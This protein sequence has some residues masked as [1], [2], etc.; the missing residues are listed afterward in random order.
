MSNVKWIKIT[1][2]MFEDEKIDFIESLPESDSIIIIWIK[3]LTIAGKCNSGGFIYLTEKIPYTENML[4]HKFK[5]PLATVRLALNTLAELDMI[6]FDEES[7]LK[8]TNWE[9]HQN[10]DGLAKIREQ[11]RKRVANYR[12][13]QKQLP[14]GN[15]TSN[16]TVTDCNPRDRELE[17][18][19]EL[20][21]ETDIYKWIIEYLNSKAN[22]NFKYTSKSTQRLIDTRIKE[23]FVLDDFKK[24]IDT[25][26]DAWQV[27][28]KMNSYLRPQTLFG[29]KFEGYLNEDIKEDTKDENYY[30]W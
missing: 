16:V 6:E 20:D 17:L 25:K 26:A 30:G 21:K 22:K 19:L 3:L 12:E 24:V 28:P 4:S 1:T 5:R 8:I 10:I 9:K 11:N 7:F 2:N 27:D 15:V 29:T 13:R 14:R 23:G 18:E